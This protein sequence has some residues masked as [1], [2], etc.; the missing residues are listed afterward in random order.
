MSSSKLLTC[1]EV[2]L[3]SVSKSNKLRLL[4]IQL[5]EFKNEFAIEELLS[6]YDKEYEL[7]SSSNV[8]EVLPLHTL[9]LSEK[10]AN[11]LCNTQTFIKENYTE[12]NFT[13]KLVNFLNYKD[14]YILLNDLFFHYYDT[15]RVVIENTD[16]DCILLKA[17]GESVVIIGNQNSVCYENLFFGSYIINFLLK[18]NISVCLWNYKGFSHNSKWY[19]YPSYN[20][21]REYSNIICNQLSSRFTNIGLWGISMGGI[22]VSHCYKNNKNV[23][24]VIFDRN[25]SSVEGVIR[26]SLSKYLLYIYK[27]F[28]NSSDTV[29]NYLSINNTCSKLLLT[30]P[31]DSIVTYFSSLKE[32]VTQKVIKVKFGLNKSLLQ[33][34]LSDKEYNKFINSL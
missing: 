10:F 14:I 3:K 23:K 33:H 7:V 18:M 17:K 16:I 32:G 9:I 27:L 21:L 31:L 20:N 13:T 24:L 25:F 12:P 2:F 28:F 34:I 30:D 19:H 26:E 29:S 22:P 5:T 8:D 11:S 4:S 15:E 1:S 6:N